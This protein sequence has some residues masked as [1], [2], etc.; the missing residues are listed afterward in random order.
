MH[1]QTFAPPALEWQ[2]RPGDREVLFP[3]REQRPELRPK[4]KEEQA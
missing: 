2:P 1:R 4:T 3:T